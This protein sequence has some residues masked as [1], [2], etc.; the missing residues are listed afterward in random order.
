MSIKFLF[1]LAKLPHSMNTMLFR[2]V[3]IILITS[4]V[5][6]SH[7]ISLCDDGIPSS[8]VSIEFNKKTPWIAHLFKSPFAVVFI[9]RLLSISL[10]MFCSDGGILMPELTE[11]A[12]P[13]ACPFP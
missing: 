12:N 3:E 5:K 2:F 11:N 10:K 6:I 9:F 13:L 4:F 1:P 7:P 8:T